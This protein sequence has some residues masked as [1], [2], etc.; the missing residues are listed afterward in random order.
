M[1]PNNKQRQKSTMEQY[2]EDT[3]PKMNGGEPCEM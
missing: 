2:C 1:E 3:Q